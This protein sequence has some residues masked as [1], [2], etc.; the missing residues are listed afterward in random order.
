MAFPAE[1]G[2][3]NLPNGNWSPTI[4]SRK[5]QKAFR[6]TSVV[7]DITNT[8][9]MG[10]IAS[11]GDSV[12]IIKEP[13][14]EVKSLKRGTNIVTQALD[15]AAFKL[16]V[17]QANY[18][19]FSLQD[20]EK[21]HSHVNWMELATDQAGYKMT[22]HFDKEVLG[23]GAG[24][25]LDGSG[26]WIARTAANGTKA[27]A[28]AGADE[29]LA[30]NKL[31]I[32]N[33]GGSDLGVEAGP[34]SIPVAPG[35]GSGAVTSLLAILNRMKRIMDQ[36]NIPTEGR[37]V[38]ID[39]IAMEV[40]GDEDSKLINADWGGEGEVRN[41]RLP[42]R[43]RGF[44]VYQSNNLPYIGNGA[45]TNAASGSETNY[46]VIIAGH[47]SAMATAEQLSKTQRFDSPTQFAEVVR[48]MHLYGRKIL[49]PEALVTAVW[50]L[51]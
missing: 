32:T 18:F 2:H 42:N 51:A 44:R 37:W 41:G 21:A 20:I 3:T 36:R 34:T 45:D 1:A 13:D 12:E 50:N 48:G 38:V 43:I 33:F 25:E 30:A 7:Q 17:D 26:D 4:F 46:N 29:L 28:L 47:D 24:Y 49:R 19:S 10:E 35:G 23:Y 9:Y 40:L 8:D 16:V 11:Y 14:I 31:D 39:P 6:K 5:A 15:D 22:D 27:N